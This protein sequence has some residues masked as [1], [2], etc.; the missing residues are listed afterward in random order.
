[1][2]ARFLLFA[3]LVALVAALV[4][5]RVVDRAPVADEEEVLRPGYFL[6]G[7]DLEEFG[8]DGQLRI[9]LQSISANED[10]SSGVVRLSDVAV[11]YHAPTGRLWHL[12]AE[13]ARVPP[14]GQVVEFEGNVRLA[15]QPGED[16]SEAQLHTARM[17][18][19]TVNEVAETRSPVELAFG[20]HRMHALGMHADLKAGSLRL[21]SDVNGNFAP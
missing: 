20:T 14:G 16:A 6:T 2:I 3:A 13:E 15:G 9:G 12:T 19:D 8:A 17:T 11:D 4:Q 1:M 5:W 21:E 10:P 7:V 18:L